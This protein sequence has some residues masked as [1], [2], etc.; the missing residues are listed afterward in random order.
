MKFGSIPSLACVGLGALLGF[1]AASKDITPVSR[2]GVATPPARQAAAETGVTD[3]PASCSE[4]VARNVLLA[5]VGSQTTTAKG[6]SASS[7]KKPNIVF[8]MGDDV[9]WFNIGAYH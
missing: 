2:A 1:V 9:G 6:A 3:R 5:Q 4:G 8:I 7:G